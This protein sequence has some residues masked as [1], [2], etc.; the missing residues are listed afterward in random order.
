MFDKPCLKGICRLL[1]CCY[2]VRRA[3]RTKFNLGF[4]RDGRTPREEKITGRGSTGRA[5]DLDSRGYR[6]EFCRPD[7]LGEEKEK[8]QKGLS[9]FKCPVPFGNF[10]E[11]GQKPPAPTNIKMGSTILLSVIIL[12]FLGVISMFFLQDVR[13]ALDV[14]LGTSLLTFLLSIL[15]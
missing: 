13:R 7:S 11:G 10:V 15:L 2:A 8:V 1:F 3:Q 12:P 4:R 9:S 6:F 5:R 14:A